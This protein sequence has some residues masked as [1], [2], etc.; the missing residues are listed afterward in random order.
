[1]RMPAYLQPLAEP[2]FRLL[3]IGQAVSAFGDAL[4]PVALVFATLAIAHTAGALG[5]VLALSLAAHV[6]AL[7]FAGVWADR[8]PRQMVML[9]SDGVRAAAYALLAA[10]LIS[11]RAQLWH[12][13]V[14]SIVYGIAGAFFHPASTALIPQTV[15]A[16]RLQQA[17]ALMGLSRST[18]QVAGPVIAG[19]LVGLLSPG[20]VFAIDSAT[21]VVSAISL[22]LLHIPASAGK[23]R[24]GFWSELAAG[25]RA[26]SSRRWYMLNLGSH[27]LWNFAIAAFFVL[28]PIVAKT[29]LGGA[30]A[31]GFIAGSLGVGSVFGGLIALRVTPRRPLV[32]GNLALTLTALQILA[33]IPPLPTVV[34]MCTC[35]IGF[36]GL[37]FLNEIWF[38]TVQQII[39]AEVLA[40]ASSFDWLVSLIA[41]PAGFAIWGPIADR[42]GIPSTLIGAAIILAVP[43]FLIVLVPGVRGVKRTDDGRIGLATES[44]NVITHG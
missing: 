9:S 22:A 6:V 36:A 37:T 38:A 7:P 35:A 31:W 29:H 39:P 11:G 3:W 15:S 30:S 28:G 25:W 27:A 18:T 14:L 33:L 34:I 5:L 4:V 44:P 41:M 17:N 8:L 40:R 24:A 21:F 16:E 32:A 43:S 12:I 2:N 23:A 1:M 13:I 42:I 10:L 20:W 26:T 19:I